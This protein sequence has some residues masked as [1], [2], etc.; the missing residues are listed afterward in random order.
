MNITWL[1]LPDFHLLFVQIPQVHQAAEL[2][3]TLHDPGVV[4]LRSPRE[5]IVENSI[6]QRQLFKIMGF[7]HIYG[8]TRI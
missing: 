3:H 4:L 8:Y 7:G 5:L 1:L 2:R 6:M